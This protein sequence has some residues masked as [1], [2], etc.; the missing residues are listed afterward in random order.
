MQREGLLDAYAERH[1]SNSEGLG[2][3][4]VLLSDNGT[5]EKLNS[6][7]GALNDTL[8]NLNGVTYVELRNLRL[9]LLLCKCFQYG[10]DA[11]PPIVI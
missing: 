6:L 3:A 1:T 5:F 7:S 2:D 9:E 4:T 10:H 8:M 11:H